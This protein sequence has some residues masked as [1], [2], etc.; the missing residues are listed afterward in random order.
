[1]VWYSTRESIRNQN[2]SVLAIVETMTAIGVTIW[3]AVHFNTL[4]H[5]AI[6]AAIA[7]FLLLR[8]PTSNNQGLV[9]AARMANFVLTNLFQKLQPRPWRNQVERVLMLPYMALLM[10]A[11][12]VVVVFLSFVIKALVALTSVLTRP[13]ETL[14]A[15]PRN[16]RDIVF[17]TDIATPPELLPGLDDYKEDDV[18]IGQFKVGRMVTAIFSD[19]GP[20]R[21]VAAVSILLGIPYLLIIYIPASLYR[22]SLKST[23]I[24]WSPLVWA[25]RPISGADDPRQFARGII[26][27]GIY[28]IARAYSAVIFL[29]L[30]FKA[31][32]FL[33]WFQITSEMEAL[34]SWKIISS[35][36]LPTSIPAWQVA[37]LI[38]VLLTWW[39][40]TR[41]TWYV[42]QADGGQQFDLKSAA[43]FFQRTF[44]VRNILSVYTSLCTLYIT[45][46]IA[47]AIRLPALQ[48]IFFPW[49]SH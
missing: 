49:M 6:S 16:W 1:M 14:A 12:E 26:N 13:V 38:N 36:L 34:P 15:I 29:F 4:T 19:L 21:S 47:T 40:Y 25:F 35:Y 33:L 37:A 46:T 7:P 9:L 32:I 24:I 3:I 45:V 23:A 30:C 10:V 44:I 5:I 42:H 17:C 28:K 43:R 20:S 22:W 11:S 31:I 48:P 2:V 41:A 8:T 18:G 39:V 27:L